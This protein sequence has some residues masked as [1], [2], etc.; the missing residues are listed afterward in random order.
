M[1]VRDR[2]RICL[3]MVD[4]I[5]NSSLE[6]YVPYLVVAEDHRYFQHFGVDP[7][8]VARAIFVRVF[9][10]KIQ[11]ASTIEQQFVR[12]VTEDYERTIKRKLREQL[13][14]LMLS[15]KRDKL[16]IATAYLSKAHYGYGLNGLQGLKLIIGYDF[17]LA[18]EADKIALV[19][20]LKYPQ[21]RL[22][23]EVWMSK[24]MNRIK[25]IRD[26]FVTAG[27]RSIRSI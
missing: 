10:G 16:D 18:S 17:K 20:R 13:I 5:S 19:S 24:H 21:P 25:Y 4:T 12:V 8:G 14:A 1:G 7:I 22:Q 11:G 26:K 2:L 23:C 3:D 15:K 6:S 9:K 27:N